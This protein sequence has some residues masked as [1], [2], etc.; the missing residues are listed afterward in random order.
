MRR[1]DIILKSGWKS[2]SPESA[3]RTAAVQ[4]LL[5]KRLIKITAA[6]KGSSCFQA[7][8]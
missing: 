2:I 5:K 4:W 7:E 1:L 3:W 8:K 6:E